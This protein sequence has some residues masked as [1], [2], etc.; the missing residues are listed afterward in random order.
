MRVQV[1]FEFD[2]D[3]HDTSEVIYDWCKQNKS[4]CTDSGA[5]FGARDMGLE[6]PTF[7]KAEELMR[8][9]KR[10]LGKKLYLYSVTLVENY[11]EED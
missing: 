2:N 1:S 8:K 6:I 10:K 7:V 3:W 11:P 4:E 9:L 5:G